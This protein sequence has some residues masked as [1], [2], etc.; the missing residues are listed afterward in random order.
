MDFE[1]VAVARIT[2]APPRFLELFGGIG[3]FAVNVDVRA[4][5]LSESGLLGNR[6][7]R[8]QLC[9]QIYWAN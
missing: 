1:S 6:G 3:G 4:E 5:F 8:R 7:R 2:R 9:I